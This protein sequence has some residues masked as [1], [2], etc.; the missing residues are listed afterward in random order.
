MI[1]DNYFVKLPLIIF[2]QESQLVFGEGHQFQLFVSAHVLHV[3]DGRADRALDN[4][5]DGVVGVVHVPLSETLDGA[6]Q[7]LGLD[8]GLVGSV[9]LLVDLEGG[10]VDDLLNIAGLVALFIFFGLA[11]HVLGTL[12]YM[13]L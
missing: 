1:K 4:R 10:I 6:V 11:Q 7:H 9:Q 5:E 8:L 3:L 2:P 12:I 13:V